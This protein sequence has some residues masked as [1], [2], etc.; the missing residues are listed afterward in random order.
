VSE[1]RR[2]PEGRPWEWGSA[3]V[4][5]EWHGGFPQHRTTCKHRAGDCEACGTTDR[6]DVTHK[7]R[8]GRGVVAEKLRRR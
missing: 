4:D 7:T 3:S 1:E 2:T 6:R 8:G 5:L